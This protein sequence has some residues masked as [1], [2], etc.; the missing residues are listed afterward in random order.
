MCLEHS[1][2]IVNS[3]LLFIGNSSYLGFSA[4]SPQFKE[5]LMVQT[6][7]HFLATRS[8]NSLKMVSCDNCM[9]HPCCLSLKDHCF[10][11]PD[12]FKTIGLYISFV[13]DFSMVIMIPIIPPWWE[14]KIS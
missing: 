4:P 3:L 8:G 1:L 11:L 9:V 7:S 6:L 13:F 5:S 14:T 10:S 2:C 12:D